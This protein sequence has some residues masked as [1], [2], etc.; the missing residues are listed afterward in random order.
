MAGWKQHF[1]LEFEYLIFYRTK[2]SNGRKHPKNSGVYQQMIVFI[3]KKPVFWLKPFAG[4]VIR[5]NL[6]R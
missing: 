3:N 4:V 6:L 5:I 2:A 1:R